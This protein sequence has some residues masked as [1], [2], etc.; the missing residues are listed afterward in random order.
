MGGRYDAFRRIASLNPVV[1]GVEIVGTPTYIVQDPF[2]YRVALNVPVVSFMS[3][4]TNYGTSFV[5]QTSLST[6]GRQ[7]KPQTGTQFEVGDR[8]SIFNNR[9][10]LSAAVY[11]MIEKN[12]AVAQANGVIDQAGEQHSKGIEAELRARVSRRLTFFANY[13]FT[14]AAYDEF[15]SQDGNGSFVELR[16][17]V[18]S[19]VARNTG[20]LWMTYDLPKGLG[21]SLGGRYLSKRPTDQFNYVFMGGFTV[22]DTALSYRRRKVEYNVLVNNVFDKTRYFVAAINHTQLYPGPPINISGAIRFRFK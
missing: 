16:G 15:V 9:L 1:N 7:L 11:H 14:N 19:F 12:V 21:V 4:Y 17:R 20:R 10:T 8:V 18:P 22:W 2:T 6:D 3:I 5:A 13:G